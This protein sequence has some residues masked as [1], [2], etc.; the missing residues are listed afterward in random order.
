MSPLQGLWGKGSLLKGSL[1]LC[2]NCA[3]YHE[4]VGGN[5]SVK[6]TFVPVDL[7]AANKKVRQCE[8]KTQTHQVWGQQF[9]KYMI[10]CCQ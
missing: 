10:F 5:S 3:F 6:E 9:Q 8:Q 1:L 2:L 4:R 7:H